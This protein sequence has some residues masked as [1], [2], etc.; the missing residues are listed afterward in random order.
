VLNRQSVNPLST[1]IFRQPDFFALA[2]KLQPRVFV[3]EIKKRLLA[4]KKADGN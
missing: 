4:W 2:S 1:I 3:E